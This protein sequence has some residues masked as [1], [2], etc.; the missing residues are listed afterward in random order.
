MIK[1]GII[2]F[3][4]SNI[5]VI[6][7]IREYFNHAEEINFDRLKEELVDKEII[8]LNNPCIDEV[9]LINSED[10]N[11]K[12]AYILITDDK[13]I[14]FLSPFLNKINL[15]HVASND[16]LKTVKDVIIR[17]S[18]RKEIIKSQRSYIGQ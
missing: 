4:N 13:T 14:S 17:E 10:K 2:N 6:K 3:P 8:V 9:S 12:V 16:E 5:Q 18:E 7:S 1:L 15:I 11:N